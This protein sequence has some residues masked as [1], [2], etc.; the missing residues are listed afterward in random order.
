MEKFYFTFGSDPAYPYERD[1]YVIALGLN[2]KDCIEAYRK[3]HPNRPGSDAV[4][5]ASFYTEG[6]WAGIED[7]YYKNVQPK[8]VIVSDN[9]YGCKPEGFSP[10]WFY[11][12]ANNQLVYLQ[13]GSGDNLLKE[14][15]DNG[16]KDYV[17]ITAYELADGTPEE[18]DGGQLMFE[19]MVQ[20]HYK[21]LADSIPD[22]LDFLYD[23]PYLEA[24][25]LRG[26]SL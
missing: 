12:P 6:E 22:V 17:D 2:K 8:E 11:V 9:A 26:A 13:E 23:S 25:I 19:Y 7:Q 24:Q 4:N 20:G 21:C 3:K 10:I 16:Y 18:T 1:D 15:L 5:C 14:D